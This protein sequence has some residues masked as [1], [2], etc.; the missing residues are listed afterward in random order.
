MTARAPQPDKRRRWRVAA[1][2]AAM[3]ALF[4]APWWSPPLLARLAFFRV[5]R[6]EVVGTHYIQADDIY[7]R[8]R[9]DSTM[10]VWD[11]SRPLEARVAGYSGV[12]S[13][14]IERK[15]PGT[16]VVRLSENLPVAFV[17]SAGGLRATD[18]EGRLL[19]L[20]PSRV[21]V[22]LPV[23]ECLDTALVRLL[24]DVQGASPALF[25]RINGARRPSPDELTFSLPG[26]TVR[27][28]GNM[29]AARLADII[30]VEQDLARRGARPA[31]LDL[32]FRDQVIARLQ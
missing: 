18:A 26:V 8:L 16:L 19:P 17:P 9:I 15:L 5:R 13:V 7:R 23:L 30:P 27:T 24:A 11:D 3:L 4:V 31:E 28:R 32:R 12:R 22:D 14:T 29:T 6:V 20:D 21:D 10:S 1:A 25:G 2:L